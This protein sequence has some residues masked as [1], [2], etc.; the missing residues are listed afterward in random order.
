MTDKELKEIIS[1]A[2]SELLKEF[3]A[4]DFLKEFHQKYP[5]YDKELSKHVAFMELNE[6]FV[7]KVLSKV[8]H[9]DSSSPEAVSRNRQSQDSDV[10]E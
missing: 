7:Y 4:I 1:V 8:F 2:H 5:T 10:Q 6:K 3:S 9:I